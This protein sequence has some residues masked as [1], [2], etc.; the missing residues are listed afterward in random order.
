MLASPIQQRNQL[1]LTR[2]LDAMFRTDALFFHS[3][4]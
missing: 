1:M 4:T 2:L 3:A